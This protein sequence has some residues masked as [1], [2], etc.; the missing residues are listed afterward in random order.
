MEPDGSGLKGTSLPDFLQGNEENFR[1]IC[2]SNAPD[3]SIYFCDWSQNI[4]GHLQHH[5]RDPNRDHQHGRIYRVTYEGRPLLTPKQIHGESIENLV[6]LL[7]EPE[8]G[9]R[10]RAKI[11]LGNRD[12]KA[13]LAVVMTWAGA[14]DKNDKDYE[15]C[16]S[17]ALWVHQWHN[18]VNMALL[19]NRLASPEPNARAAAVRVALYLRDRVPDVLAIIKTAALDEAPVPGLPSRFTGRNHKSRCVSGAC[20]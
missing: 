2:V 13:V 10:E 19:K 5:L 16:L 7:A 17:E 20:A 3:G 15:H 18:V 1:P 9:V 11:E 4:I 8:D 6:K 14:L 12:T